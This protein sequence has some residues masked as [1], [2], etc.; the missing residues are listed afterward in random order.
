MPFRPSP[1]PASFRCPAPH[2]RRPIKVDD[3]HVFPRGYLKDIG[4][5]NEI[6]SV[7]N[8]CL[9]DRQTNS[10]IG[11]KP[12]SQYLGEIRSAL[13]DDLDDVLASHRLP[14]GERSPLD[15][16]DFD[17]FLSWRLE[18]LDDALAEQTGQLG[19]PAE[20][21]DPFRTRLD[22][23]IEG[24]ELSLRRLI[25][26]RVDGERALLPA[27]V[28]QRVQERVVAAARK[29]PED[30]ERR[31]AALDAQLEYFDLRELQDVITSKSLWP[32]FE[33][34]FRTK[35]TLAVRFGQ[36]AE[37]RN[38]IRHSRTLTDVAIKDG[39]AAILWFDS[40]LGREEL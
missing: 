27:H 37:L 39:E 31:L 12:P 6:D 17:E 5:P 32:R 13:G 1:A 19:V 18:E 26:D 10:S 3:H 34:T 8:H 20:K 38:A 4:R 9:I 11:K 15:S 24:V 22:A 14:T 2:A 21:Q 33:P 7:L 28:Q 29:L 16:D 36:L 30:A 25:A 40:M 35:E 23:K